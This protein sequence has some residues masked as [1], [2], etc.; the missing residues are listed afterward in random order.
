MRRLTIDCSKKADEI[1]GIFKSDKEVSELVE[2]QNQ[3]VED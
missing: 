3:V 2:E 1:S